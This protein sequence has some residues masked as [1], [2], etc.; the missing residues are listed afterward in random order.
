ML[1]STK[2]WREPNLIKDTLLEI[3]IRSFYAFRLIDI[4]FTVWNTGVVTLWENC[5]QLKP[6]HWSHG[7][8]RVQTLFELIA[9]R[10]KQKEIN[11]P[12]GP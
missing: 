12:Y 1:G 4:R 5:Y 3:Q 10:G 9:F 11:F 6:V 7:A 2:T 8:G